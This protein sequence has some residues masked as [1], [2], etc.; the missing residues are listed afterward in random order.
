[1]MRKGLEIESSLKGNE[2]TPIMARMVKMTMQFDQLNRLKVRK[3]R[4]SN[5]FAILHFDV[6]FSCSS[7]FIY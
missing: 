2:Q 4:V 3:I 6:G 5:N 1:M 7:T